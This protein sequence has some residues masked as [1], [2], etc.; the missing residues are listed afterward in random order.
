MYLLGAT[1]HPTTASLAFFFIGNSFS[2]W[3]GFHDI[4][5]FEESQRISHILDIRFQYLDLIVSS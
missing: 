2:T 5:F 4:E 3:F 1:I